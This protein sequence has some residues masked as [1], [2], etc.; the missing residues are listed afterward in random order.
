MKHK[1][2]VINGKWYYTPDLNP[3][4]KKWAQ[5]KSYYRKWSYYFENKIQ[6]LE[7]ILNFNCGARLI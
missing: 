6:L 5:V 3:I 2:P 4:E 7:M 1:C